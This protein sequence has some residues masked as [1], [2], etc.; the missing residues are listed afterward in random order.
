MRWPACRGQ[1]AAREGLS[2]VGW[3]V[4]EAHSTGE[5]GND[6]RGKG[7]WLKE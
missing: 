4:G 7:P 1:L 5:A 6:R 3:D 2:R